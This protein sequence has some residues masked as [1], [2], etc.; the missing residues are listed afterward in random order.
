MIY[1]NKNLKAYCVS[2]AWEKIP[3]QFSWNMITF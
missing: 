2:F 1:T 3:K